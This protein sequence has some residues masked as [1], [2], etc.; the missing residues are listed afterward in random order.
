MRTE[1]RGNALAEWTFFN[2]SIVEH[3]NEFTQQLQSNTGQCHGT[4]G[5]K[6]QVLLS[7][8]RVQELK[9]LLASK[10]LAYDSEERAN[11]QVLYQHNGDMVHVP[12]GWPHQVLNLK[13]C[14]K[15]AWDYHD[16]VNMAQYALSW[17]YIRGKFMPRGDDYL[18]QLLSSRMLLS[19]CTLSSRSEV[20]NQ[21]I[22][23][24]CV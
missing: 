9:M 5:L 7:P 19:A 11:V 8:K 10:N 17:L 24:P 20:P 15:L 3:V 1:E 2:P 13:P 6:G 12:A 4:D 18:G 16:P 23:S 22:M 14:V 21:K